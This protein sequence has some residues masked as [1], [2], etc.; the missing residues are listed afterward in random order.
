MFLLKS[1]TVE[2]LFEAIENVSK[3]QEF[4]STEAKNPPHYMPRMPTENIKK[5]QAYRY[6]W[7]NKYAVQ[8]NIISF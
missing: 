7:L 1:S 5:A 4:F 2:E 8:Y 6:G 3:D